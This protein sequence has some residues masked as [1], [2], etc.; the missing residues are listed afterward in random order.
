M[1][2]PRQD[3]VYFC[4]M[5]RRRI[6]LLA[7][8]LLLRGLA[9]Q[10][11]V[12]K[13][14]TSINSVAYDES[15]PV[16]SRDGQSLFFTRTAFPDFDHTLI[17]EYGPIP[18]LDD[19]HAFRTRLADIYSQ[20]AGRDVEDPYTSSFN[21]DIWY[22][23]IG[24]ETI[25]APLHPGFPLNSALP[26]SLLGCSERSDEY[27]VLN[28]FYADGSMMQGFSRIRIL[29]GQAETLPS[30]LHI[31]RFD[32]TRSDV[33]MTM[34]RDGDVLLLGMRGPDSRGGHDLYVSLYLRENVWS[35]PW[36]IGAAINTPFQETSPFLSPDKRFMYFASDRP[37]GRGGLDLYVSERLDYTWKHW[38]TPTPVPG[39]VNTVADESQPF[40]DPERRYM[41]FASRRDGSSDIFRQVVKPQPG[42]RKPIYVRGRIV[43]TADGKPVHGEVY[44]GA[45]DAAAYLDYFNSFTG[46]FE[47][48]LTE[49][50]TYRFESRKVG[51]RG[52]QLL[53]DAALLDSLGQ[54][55]VDIIIR[56]EPGKPP[57][58]A[59][60]P[61]I[62]RSKD[63]AVP[64]LTDIHFARAQ[65]VIL[66]SSAP[67]LTELLRRLRENP[68]MEI[69]VEGHTDNIGDEG[70]LVDLSVRRADAVKAYLVE[71]GIEGA[72][73]RTRGFGPMRPRYD[74]S[75][76]AGRSGNRRVEI[77]IIRT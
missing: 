56:V 6:F 65:A 41:Y 21:Q 58:P 57:R 64:E 5:C 7:F 27:V 9:A 66:P 61:V 34:T 50:Q 69:R 67:A 70:A 10:E 72:R 39:D 48:M 38:S 28:Q 4:A 1:I 62:S 53:L 15:S 37:G 16:I 52:E 60:M 20:L 42:L 36:N 25:S 11:V 19:E 32:I 13:L 23:T 33:N 43:S 55:T 73:I 17:D 40:F 51:H 71:Q 47:V 68:T 24:G 63:I 75:T 12:E 8:G 76:E 18:G 54:D 59:P 3:V 2:R 45:E 49:R 77:R 31:Y 30:P 35:A 74:N 29:D 26:N 14:P 44:W 22:A 46:E